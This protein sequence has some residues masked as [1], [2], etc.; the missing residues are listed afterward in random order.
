MLLQPRRDIHGIAEIGDLPAR[1]PALADHHR[2]GVKSGAKIR[3][4]AELAPIEIRSLRNPVL[5][6]KE[7][8]EVT[9]LP[10]LLCNRP[11]HDDLVPDIGVDLAVMSDDRLVD[12]EEELGEELMHAQLSHLFRQR[13]RSGEIEEQQHAL[14][15]Y[16]PSIPSENEV[17]KDPA[18]DEP[19]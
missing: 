17:D 3:H 7:A 9:L 4:Q 12:V 19:R 11:R 18:A 14:L 1:I 13:R 8:I 10:L 15:S 5:D 16:G 2:S 6:R